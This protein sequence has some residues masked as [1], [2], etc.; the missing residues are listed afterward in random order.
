MNKDQIVAYLIRKT[1]AEI[2]QMLLEEKENLEAIDHEDQDNKNVFESTA[3]EQTN[4]IAQEDEVLSH[5]RERLQT[6]KRISSEPTSEVE[7]GS[8]VK[9]NTGVVLVGA[10]FPTVD[11][12]GIKVTGVSVASPIF[13]KMQ[14]M[15][16]GAEFH[17]T[18]HPQEYVILDVE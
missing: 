4:A 3:E 2:E 8:L 6:L 14:G 15:S 5:A 11:V 10:S 1:E 12:E 7:F 16:K 9:L 13:Q 18:D 17:L